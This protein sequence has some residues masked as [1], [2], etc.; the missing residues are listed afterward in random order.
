MAFG[1]KYWILA[2]RYECS[3]KCS[4]NGLNEASHS[5]LPPEVQFEFP[6]FV[7]K[8]TALDKS[9]IDILENM[10]VGGFR[11]EWPRVQ[12]RD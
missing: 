9:A 2:R 8:S 12:I 6:A 5:Q 7:R 10:V 4:F 3:C 1:K 11:V